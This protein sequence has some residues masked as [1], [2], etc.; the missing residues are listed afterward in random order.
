MKGTWEF[1]PG[2]IAALLYVRTP[3]TTGASQAVVYLRQT[4]GAVTDRHDTPLSESGWPQEVQDSINAHFAHVFSLEH[5][6]WRGPPDARSPRAA[7]VDNAQ[8]WTITV[9]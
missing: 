4:K 1:I 3:E 6:N 9:N 2:S 7:Y 8:P 5:E